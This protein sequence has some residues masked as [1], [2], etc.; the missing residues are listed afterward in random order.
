MTDFSKCKPGGP[1]RF[2]APNGN[3]PKD[4]D[5]C[6]C[7]ESTWKWPSEPK[8]ALHEGWCSRGACSAPE[9]F[10]NGYSAP[11]IG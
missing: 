4:G 10:P 11:G 7:G 3:L 9:H 1:H 6:F 8:S 5:A 2:P